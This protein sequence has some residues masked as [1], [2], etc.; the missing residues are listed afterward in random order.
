MHGV[1]KDQSRLD[2]LAEICRC[3][4]LERSLR[5][6]RTEQPHRLESIAHERGRLERHLAALERTVEYEGR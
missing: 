3:D 1:N 2:L 5:A 4:T 6:Q